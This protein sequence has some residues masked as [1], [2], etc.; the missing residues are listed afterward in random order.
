MRL[1]HVLLLCAS[2]P[3]W[4][5]GHVSSSVLRGSGV[6]CARDDLMVDLS[7][8][9][10]T[11]ELRNPVMPASGTFAELLSDVIDINQLGAIVTKTI[12]ADVR[13]GNP[14]PR[15]TEFKDAVLWSIGIPSKGWIH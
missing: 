4:G 2:V 5:E 13:E 1:G 6:R 15:I 7:V 9:V 12:T 14:P 8:K 11:I 10:G 3:S